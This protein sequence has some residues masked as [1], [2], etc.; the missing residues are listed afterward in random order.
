MGGRFVVMNEREA[1]VAEPAVGWTAARQDMEQF[2]GRHR[3][4]FADFF[5]PGQEDKRSRRA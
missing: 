5:E 2:R 3:A 1:A 4:D